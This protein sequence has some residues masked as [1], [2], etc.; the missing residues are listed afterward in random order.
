M[1]LLPFYKGRVFSPSWGEFE[2][3]CMSYAHD[4]PQIPMSLEMV[5]WSASFNLMPFSLLCRRRW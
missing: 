4:T 3:M 2:C 1:S 5:L